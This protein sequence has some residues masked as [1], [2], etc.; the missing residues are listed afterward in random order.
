VDTLRWQE[1]RDLVTLGPRDRRYIL[2]TDDDDATTAI[3]GTGARGA[4]P[5]TG[6]ENVSARYRTGVGIGG[7]VAAGKISQ[8]MTR[9]LGAS[10]VVNPLPSTG[11]ADR[12][13]LEQGRRNLPLGVLALDRLVSVPDYEDFAR[14]RAGIGQASATALS[15]GSK[16]V[17]HLTIAGSQDAPIDPS[18]D[19][20]RSLRL[21]LR[22][23]GDPVL[24]VVVAVRELML[25]ITAINVRIMD[26]RRWLDMEPRIRAGLLERFS[27]DQRRLGQE[28][29]K[30][31]LQA[32][33]QEIPGVVYSDIDTLDV[34]PESI[35][36]EG[37]GG[38]ASELARPARDR[39]PVELARFQEDALEIEADTT[40]GTLAAVAARTGATL[41]TLVRLNPDLAC[42]PLETGTR[43]VLRRGIRPA[44]IAL[45]SASVPDTLILRNV[46]S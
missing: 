20:F 44:Q 10:E 13:S 28:V 19:L 32:A 5:T 41:Q 34:V 2:R 29:L 33:I 12:E 24:P 46:T 36:L 40:E 37:L 21:A 26:D 16:R 9:P 18:S 15:D 31:E 7:N 38:L 43:V 22:E 35:T 27:F 23:A 25:L 1:A 6:P 17:V 14:A 39:V 8:L 42:K 30:S 3:F 11:G 45:L 4:R